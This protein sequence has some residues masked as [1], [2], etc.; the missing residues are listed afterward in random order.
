MT[1]KNGAMPNDTH[2][3]FLTQ[4]VNMCIYN[5]PQISQQYF[6][7]VKNGKNNHYSFITLN[8]SGF[9]KYF[10]L[11][12]EYNHRNMYTSGLFL[13]IKVGSVLSTYSVIE[14]TYKSF[15]VNIKNL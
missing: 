1:D 7:F 10:C 8:S 3:L 4:H 11:Q 5:I 12:T 13:H 6:G 15:I 2:L 14:Q 9:E